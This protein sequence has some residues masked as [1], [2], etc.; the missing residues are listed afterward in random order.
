VF[1]AGRAF[2]NQ[3]RSAL[4]A[5]ADATGML[6]S[7]AW[8]TLTGIVVVAILLDDKFMGLVA[9]GLIRTRELAAG[10]PQRANGWVTGAFGLDPIVGRYFVGTLAGIGWVNGPRRSTPP[11]PGPWWPPR[12]CSNRSG[13]RHFLLSTIVSPK[14][15]CHQSNDSAVV[16]HLVGVPDR[17]C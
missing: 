17:S 15:I 3:H 8:P 4:A 6:A 13:V 9:Q 5:I 14:R 10:D 2:Q 7:V 11:Q 1:L 16:L 12:W